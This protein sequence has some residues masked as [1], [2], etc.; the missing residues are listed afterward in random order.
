MD[1]H[2]YIYNI[3]SSLMV[4]CVLLRKAGLYF[5]TPYKY[6]V[7]LGVYFAGCTLKAVQLYSI[8]NLI[9]MT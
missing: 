3:R 4:K 1:E 7:L 2:I 6:V 9:D 5:L 8:Y